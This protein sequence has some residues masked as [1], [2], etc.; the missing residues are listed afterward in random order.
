MTDQ[1]ATERALAAAADGASRFLRG[2][3]ERPVAASAGAE[4]L[5]A[6]LGGPLPDGPS[7]PAEVV[8][9]LAALADDGLVAS[10]G[11]RFF[12][13]VVGGGRPG[14]RLGCGARRPGRGAAGPGR[15]RGRAARHHRR[16]PA[17]PRPGQRPGPGRRRRRPGPHGPRR[18][19][20]DAGRRSGAGDR[21]R[22]GRQCQQRGRRPAGGALRDRPRPRRL[23]ARGRGVRAVGGGQPGPAAPGRRGRAGRLGGHRRPQVAECAL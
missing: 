7:D 3:P 12:G 13:F 14:R 11:P 19:G 9:Q 17:L 18:P 16:R 5:R 20:Q 21:L 6:R 22:P 4:E 2:L 1:A 23:G 8:A 10:A 15:G